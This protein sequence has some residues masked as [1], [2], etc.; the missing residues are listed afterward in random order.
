MD[1]LVSP[2]LIKEKPSR[3]YPIDLPHESALLR[4]SLKLVKVKVA[5]A[6]RG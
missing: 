3:E 2:D 4:R 5:I 1:L 6:R